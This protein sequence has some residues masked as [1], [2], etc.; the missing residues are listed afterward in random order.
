MRAIQV[1]VAPILLKKI[2]AAAQALATYKV[3]RKEEEESRKLR[4]GAGGYTS[5]NATRFAKRVFL[6][7][8]ECLNIRFRNVAL[9]NIDSLKYADAQAERLR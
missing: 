7:C 6:R 5:E 3:R 9:D 4:F 8:P 2:D 1:L